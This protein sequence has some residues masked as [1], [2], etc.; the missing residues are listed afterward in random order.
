MI[1]TKHARRMRQIRE[2]NTHQYNKSKCYWCGHPYIR[3]HTRQ[4]YCS[5]ECQ[6]EAHLEQDRQYQYKRRKQRKRLGTTRITEHK[7]ED[8][9]IEQQ[10]IQEE[11]RRTGI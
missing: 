2:E 6:K 7:Q 1:N 8:D 10:V 9:N 5:P 4:K 11:R 3:R